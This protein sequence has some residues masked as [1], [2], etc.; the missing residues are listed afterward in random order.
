M[1]TPSRFVASIVATAQELHPPMPYSR[2]AARAAATRT[3][4]ASPALRKSA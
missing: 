3:V 4:K 2:R 1:K